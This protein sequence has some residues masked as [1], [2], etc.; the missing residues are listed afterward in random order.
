M[1][2][3]SE[4]LAHYRNNSLDII[5]LPRLD[6]AITHLN[7]LMGENQLS[8]IDVIACRSYREARRA[9]L[10]IRHKKLYNTSD[11]TVARELG[12]LK[13]AS[14]NALKWKL[15]TAD[16]M[17]TFEIPNDLPKRVIWLLDDEMK[18]MYDTAHHDEIMY[19]FIKL[20]YFTGSRRTAIESLEWSQV[21]LINK[22][23]HLAKP[24]E[25]KTNKRRPT[26]PLNAAMCEALSDFPTRGKYRYVFRRNTNRYGALIKL[27]EDARI[28][29]LPEKD[30]R[31]AGRMTPHILRHTRATHLLENGMPLYGVAKLLGDNPSTVERVYAHAC[32]SKLRDCLDRYSV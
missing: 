9:A 24:D 6:G 7:D 18:R 21:D 19:M 29:D 8:D 11:S 25:K 22:V 12:V 15:L 27:F 32:V 30:G 5:D 1:V 17:P 2:S 13:A 31:P 3:V 28:L 14:N 26:I 10:V 4:A 23:I 16:L 20:L